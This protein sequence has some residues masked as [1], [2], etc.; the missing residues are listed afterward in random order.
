MTGGD[1]L[2]NGENA[3]NILQ[4]STFLQCPLAEMAAAD[5]M[6]SNIN[7]VNILTWRHPIDIP[8]G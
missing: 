1:V 4:A 6:M 8:F 2:V 5:Y 7:F 3:Q